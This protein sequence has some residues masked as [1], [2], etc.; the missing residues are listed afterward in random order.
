MKRYGNLYKQIYDFENLYNAYIK[1]RKNKRYRQ[2]VLAFTANL[3]ENLISIQNELVWETYKV[4]KYREFYVYEPKKRLI[5]ALPFRDRVVQWAIYQVI[6]PIFE[7]G[8][9]FHSYACRK[10]KGTHNAAKNVQ[11]WLKEV[12]K[13][14][15]EYYY[16]KLDISK[17]FYRVNHR[18]L[19][20]ILGRKIKDEQLLNLF[21]NLIKN[22]GQNFGL[23]LWTEPGETALVENVGMPIGNLTSQ[24]F[25]NVYLNELDTFVKHTLREKYYTRYMDDVIILNESKER[26][27][28]V[29]KEIENFVNEKLELHLNNKTALR[30]V[31]TGICFVGFRIWW[32]HKRM[33]KKTLVKMKSRIK[34]ITKEYRR[35]NITFQKA[36]A[37]MQSYFGIMRH[38]ESYT[39]RKNIVRNFNFERSE[40]NKENIIT[41]NI[42]F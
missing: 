19:L 3:E 33:K 5:M 16:L 6:N 20:E 22:E 17:Y 24:L 41:D 2:E 40:R 31:K 18:I 38:F 15:K 25:A 37:T 10:D 11:N 1:A 26:L 29:L 9:Q 42:E 23:P 28:Q 30:P 35:N 8:F 27:H 32:S 4:G 7:K 34:Y 39:L 12:N 36:N 21:K 13:T 14:Q